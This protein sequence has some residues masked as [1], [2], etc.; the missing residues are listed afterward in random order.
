MNRNLTQQPPFGRF[1][2]VLKTSVAALVLAHAVETSNAEDWTGYR[3]PSGNG[4]SSEKISKRWPA[5]GLRVI[6]KTPTADG[7]SSFAVANGKAFT[8]VKRTIEGVDREVCIALDANTG[9]ELW[10]TPVGVARYGHDG[11]NAGTRDNSGGDGPRSTP[12]IDGNRVYILSS[13]LVLS[14]FEADTGKTVWSRNL[15]R[16]NGAKN[17]TWKNAASPLI[18]GNLILICSG[19]DDQSL[20]GINK[21]DGSV[22]WK[23][24]SDPMTHATPVA[25]TIH[26]VRQII[27]FTQKGLVAVAPADGA[28]LWRYPFPYN[29]S[30]AASPVVAGDIVYCSAGYNVGSGAVRISKAGDKL[31]AK[32]IW[33]KPNE[34]VNHWSTPIHKDGYLY[35]M[36]GFKEYGS[37]PLACV[38]LATGKLIWSKPGFGPGN[39]VLVDGHLL[40]LGDAGQLVLVEPNAAEYKE[41]SRFDALEGKC[42]STPA[43]SNGRIYIRSTKEGACLDIAAQ[44]AQK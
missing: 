41:V 19:G 7:F 2:T 31:E 32:E 10:S 17:I 27:F 5:G 21:A 34:N 30:T 15:V 13:D 22:V 28:V 6:W 29:V 39:V 26:G 1:S 35:G 3:G 9:K 14:C 33:R 40:A 42:W 24:Q 23:S 44:A 12:T 11:G 18:E 38:E 16:E 8:Q 37:C 20:L 43:V 25:A 4:T 36:F